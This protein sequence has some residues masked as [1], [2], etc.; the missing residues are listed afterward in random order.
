LSSNDSGLF[1]FR[2][3]DVHSRTVRDWQRNQFFEVPLIAG[4]MRRRATSSLRAG[5]LVVAAFSWP[6]AAQAPRPA[7]TVFE[8]A[9]LIVGDGSV[10]ENAAFVVENGRVTAVG[11]NGQVDVVNVRKLHAAGVRQVAR[12]RRGR[13]W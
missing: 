10:I 9:R 11:R 4:V 3:V 8:G 12:Q 1:S 13:R 2:F 5:L 6:A 7:V